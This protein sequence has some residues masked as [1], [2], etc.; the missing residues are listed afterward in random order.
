MEAW[1]QFMRESLE[2]SF[3][4]IWSSIILFRKCMQSYRSPAIVGE[5]KP[6]KHLIYLRPVFDC[7]LDSE[8]ERCFLT[9]IHDCKYLHLHHHF[10]AAFVVVDHPSMKNCSVR[11]VVTQRVDNRQ[12]CLR[13]LQYFRSLS[14]HLINA[15]A[16]QFGK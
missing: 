7:P 14:N 9:L 8:I 15:V 1:E 5:C 12:V 6:C 2:R 16:C 10:A 11:K 13:S 3:C 4:P